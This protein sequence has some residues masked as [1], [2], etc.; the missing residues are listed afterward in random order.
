MWRI[1]T[2][3][4]LLHDYR[5][6]FILFSL[7]YSSPKFDSSLKKHIFQKEKKRKLK[8]EKHGILPWLRLWGLTPA[9]IL[10]FFW[11]TVRKR[12][13]E[14]NR[15]LTLVF[16]AHA[17]KA[18]FMHCTILLFFLEPSQ[19]LSTNVKEYFCAAI[20][21]LMILVIYTLQPVARYRLQLRL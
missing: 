5:R 1:L 2:L 18:L 4:S 16:E 13:A 12:V 7:I 10:L 8:K 11:H 15:A 20:S 19:F 14:T 3:P 17:A 9:I 6:H 21:S